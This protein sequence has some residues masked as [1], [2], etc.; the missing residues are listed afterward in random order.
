MDLAALVIFFFPVFC[1]SSMWTGL[2]PAHPDCPVL[3]QQNSLSFVSKPAR[4][5]GIYSDKKGTRGRAEAPSVFFRGKPLSRSTQP[6]LAGGFP[7][8]HR[9]LLLT[10]SK[11]QQDIFWPSP[12][13][14]CL[15]CP[16]HLLYRSLL[17]FYLIINLTTAL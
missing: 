14:R 2:L 13:C 1:S 17:S 7:I 15:P 3:R 4:L 5:H 11:E 8:L 12:L 9:L 6:D 16:S 10:V